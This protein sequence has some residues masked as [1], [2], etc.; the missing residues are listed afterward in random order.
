MLNTYKMKKKLSNQILQQ[1]RF[2]LRKILC[3]FAFP[4]KIKILHH[5]KK[6][7]AE[8][9]RKNKVISYFNSGRAASI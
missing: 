9:K 4:L 7:S 1:K 8:S 3:H 6:L 2:F 5:E